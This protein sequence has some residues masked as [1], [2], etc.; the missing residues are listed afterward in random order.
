L[1]IFEKYIYFPSVSVVMQF[2]MI[3]VLKRFSSTLRLSS[4]S[5]MILLL[6]PH[7]LFAD[8]LDSLLHIHDTATIVY[9]YNRTDSLAIGKTYTVPGNRV[10]GFQRYN[11]LDQRGRFSASPSNV[12]L[13]YKNLIFQPKLSDGFYTGMESFD[14]YTFTNE[15]TRYFRHLIPVTYL[16][17]INGPDKEQ[18]FRVVH[19]HSIKR[20][21]NIGVDF[22]LINSPGDYNNQKSDDKSVVFTGQ[23]FTKDLRFGAIANYRH[24]KLLVRENGGIIN[25][26]IFEENLETDPRL[27]DVNLKTAQNLVKE[28]GVM[29]NSYFY[30]S[31]KP[32]V[33]DSTK[34]RPPTFH[35]GRIEYTFN[36][37]RQSQVYSDTDPLV[38]YYAPFGPILDSSKTYDSLRI[39]SFENRFSWSNLRM[40]DAPEKKYLLVIFS[41]SNKRSTISDSVSDKSFKNWIPEA[42]MIIRPYRLMAIDLSGKYILGDFNNTG[43]ELKGKINQSY[44]TKKDR[45]GDIGFSFVTASQQAGYFFTNFNSNYFRWDTAFS[46]QIIQKAAFTLRYL[47]LTAKVEYQF[48]SDYVYLDQQATP[49]Q[50]KGS[51]NLIRAEL[52]DEFRWKVW[53]FDAQLVYT[54]NSNKDI[55]RVPD[56][57]ARVSIY[58][59]LSL[60]KNAA[61]LQPGIDIMYNT[62]YYA[63]AYMPALRMFYLQDEKKIGNYPYIDIFAN[64]MVKR[65]RIFVKYQHLNSLWS[66]N[67]YYMIPHYPMEGASFKFGLS[68]SFYD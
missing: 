41:I 60:F 38:S 4:L 39:N 49:R 7:S 3:K 68:W 32:E 11:P 16:Q 30:L 46:N 36:Y 13:P 26:A 24:N 47:E 8:K 20:M 34:M 33:N 1:R 21:I 61:V 53:G 64:L 35:A 25:D 27:I 12:G 31:G 57:L 14:A 52:Y 62:A 45:N 15:N 19:S 43:F 2:K 58:P 6:F 65:F 29:A 22:F 55:I 59:T 10:T 9:F 51:L 18:L 5:L 63:S 50:Y 56:F 44:N 54:A 48:I 66:Q 40:G 42:N 37:T 17:Y 23:Y 28:S 67:K